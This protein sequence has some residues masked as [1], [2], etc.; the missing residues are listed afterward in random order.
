M[1]SRLLRLII[2]FLCIASH[3]FSQEIFKPRTSPLDVTS[4]RFKDAY[5]KIVYSRPHKKG[6][7]IFGKLVPYGEVW[8]TGAN[9][10][11]EL[12]LTRDLQLNNQLL[13]AGTYCI[14]TI[15]EKEKWTVI[16][17]SDVG[18]MGSYNY[19]PT[20]DVIR[21]E[22]PVELLSERVEV[23]TIMFDQNNDLANLLIIWDNVKV[24]I[25]VKFL[26]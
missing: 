14:F 4:M 9:E 22:V 18:Q 25:P 6:R 19:T 2:I 3:S 17:N 5:A 15:P 16:V 10:S 24:T 26:N 20:L 21:F 23:F 7:E 1:E 13:K 12:T 11:T 8:R